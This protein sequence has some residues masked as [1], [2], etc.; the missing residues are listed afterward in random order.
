MQAGPWMEG[1]SGPPFP[2]KIQ[3]LTW[4]ETE[5]GQRARVSSLCRLG[6]KKN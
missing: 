5:L 2:P 3:L 1:N 6:G 4:G